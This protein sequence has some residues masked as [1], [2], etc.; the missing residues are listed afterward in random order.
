[1][2]HNLPNIYP[3]WTLEAKLYFNFKTNGMPWNQHSASPCQQTRTGRHKN[4]SK[5]NIM[6]YYKKSHQTLIQSNTHQK[7]TTKNTLEPF[8][9][10]LSNLKLFIHQQHQNQ[11]SNLSLTWIL[12]MD[13][14]FLLMLY[15]KWSLN[16]EYLDPRQKTL[17][18]HFELDKENLSHSSILDLF[19]LE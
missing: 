2:H 18:F 1:M 9:F 4:N 16:L 8:E 17:W 13:L 19:K 12:T 6:I 14:T 7:E 3:H 15:F 5:Q 11:M 10:T